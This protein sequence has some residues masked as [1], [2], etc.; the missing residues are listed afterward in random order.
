MEVSTSKVIYSQHP[1]IQ[2]IIHKYEK[3][4]SNLPMKLP[5]ERRNEHIIQI[6][7]DS[8]H[9]NIKPYRYTHHQKMEIERLIQ[10]PLGC[11]IITRSRRPYATPVVLFRKKD[12]SFRLCVDYRGLNKIKIKNIFS[13]LFID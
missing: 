12:G 6:K 4:F 5:T 3:V 8:T 7:P 11:G 10:D 1:E 13:I 9:V 2:G